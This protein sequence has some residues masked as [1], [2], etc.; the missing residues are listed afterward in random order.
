[1]RGHRAALRQNSGFP[2]KKEGRGIVERRGWHELEK[3]VFNSSR[4]LEHKRTPGWKS[5][6]TTIIMVST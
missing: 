6:A 1:M 3:P 5:A 2:M 4:K